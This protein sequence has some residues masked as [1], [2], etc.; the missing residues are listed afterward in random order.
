M[1]LLVGLSQHCFP[2]LILLLA[3]L[4]SKEG[5]NYCHVIL[6]DV[7][8]GGGIRWVLLLTFC[9]LDASKYIH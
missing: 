9:P 2:F 4:A 5:L 3:K 8:H 1:S 6:D 7:F